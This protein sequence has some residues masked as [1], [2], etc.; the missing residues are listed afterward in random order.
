MYL[1]PLSS[2]TMVIMHF[3]CLLTSLIDLLNSLNFDRM[4][5]LFLMRQ[6]FISL[7]NSSSSSLRLSVLSSSAFENHGSVLFLTKVF[8]TSVTR[9]VGVISGP[10]PDPLLYRYCLILLLEYSSKFTST[11]SKPLSPL[12][13]FMARMCL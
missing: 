10:F 9:D 13:S 4:R 2:I 6:S 11:N 1:L 5:S 12:F 8:S 7:K 3:C